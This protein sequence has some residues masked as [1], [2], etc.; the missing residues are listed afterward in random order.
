M[1]STSSSKLASYLIPALVTLILVLGAFWVGMAI[2]ER[3]ARHFSGWCDGYRR[4]FMPMGR[5]RLPFPSPHLPNTHG[6]F[7]R[8]LSLSEQGL[9]IQGNNDI[10]QS[11][12]VTSSTAI[13]MGNRTASLQDIHP[14]DQV[15][16]FGMSNNKGEIEAKLVRLLPPPR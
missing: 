8:V 9:I 11:V 6:V 5:E 7:G 14:M 15:S 1:T 10:E 3:R 12:L 13:R 2:G 16:V 4:A